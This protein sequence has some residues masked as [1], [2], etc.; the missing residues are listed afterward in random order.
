MQ[1]VISESEK[2][3]E[4]YPSSILLWNQWGHQLLK[5]RNRYSNYC[6]S[7]SNYYQLTI[8]LIIILNAYKEQGHLDQALEAY[9]KP[10]IK[11]DYVEAYYN[12]GIIFHEKDKPKDAI[13]IKKLSP[14]N[15]LWKLI[16]ILV[17]FTKQDT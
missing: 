2:L 12:I 3:T 15:S 11:P 4:Q 5:Q 16:I 14:S 6:I 9:Q 8:Q 7:K 1:Q 17:T 13:T 10:F